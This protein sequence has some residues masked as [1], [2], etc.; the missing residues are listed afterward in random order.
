MP[1]GAAVQAPPR[2]AGRSVPF[3]GRDA[4]AQLSDF[5]PQSVNFLAQLRQGPDRI[6]ELRGGLVGAGSQE[7]ALALMADDEPVGL[8][9]I[10]GRAGHGHRNS[11]G[12]LEIP[13]RGEL[14]SLCEL[15]TRDASP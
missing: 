7:H 1:H 6:G 11:V 5:G 9:L 12:L 13:V 14:L 10:D 3:Q 2:F 4:F 15:A 8:E